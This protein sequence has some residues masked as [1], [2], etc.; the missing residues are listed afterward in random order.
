MDKVSNIYMITNK[1]NNKKYI[2][3]A[4]NKKERYKQHKKDSKYKDYVFYRAIRKYG[5]DNFDFK[6]LT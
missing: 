5:F 4:E 1:T 6:I 2:G 3:Q